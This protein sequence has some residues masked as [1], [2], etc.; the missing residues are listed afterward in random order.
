MMLNLVHWVSGL[1]VQDVKRITWL[2]SKLVQASAL[3]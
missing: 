2:I 3:A 1:T